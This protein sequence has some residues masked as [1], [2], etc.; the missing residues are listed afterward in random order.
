M[1]LTPEEIKQLTD[2]VVAHETGATPA[3]LAPTDTASSTSASDAST[4]GDEEN[5]TD[6]AVR[7]M[8]TERRNA[9]LQEQQR[10]ESLSPIRRKYEDTIN[11]LPEPVRAPVGYGLEGAAGYLGG[12]AIGSAT[13]ALFPEYV[14]GTTKEPNPEYDAAQA[15][16]KQPQINLNDFNS[17][18]QN[19]Q[20]NYEKSQAQLQAHEPVVQNHLQALQEHTNKMDELRNKLDDAHFNNQLL[21]DELHKAKFEHGAQLL[22]SPDLELH[23]LLGPPQTPP[24]APKDKNYYGQND[25]RFTN[26][27]ELSAANAARN[28]E[29]V[30]GLSSL[31][32]NPDEAIAKAPGMTATKSGVLGPSEVVGPF[33]EE[34]NAAHQNNI[35]EREQQK[36]IITKQIASDQL[37][38]ENKLN[39]ISAQQQA[40]ADAVKEHKKAVAEHAKAVPTLP[41]DVEKARQNAL[42][43]EAEYRRL[44]AKTP[45]KVPAENQMLRGLSAFGR[46]GRRFVPG[47]GAAVAPEEAMQAKQDYEAGNYGRMATHGAGALGAV[48]QATDIP[49]LVGVGNTMQI[50]SAVLAGY[51]YLNPGNL[52]GPK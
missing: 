51:D 22:R 25:R 14:P 13:K 9:Q 35:S 8:E 37:A 23:D 24:A 20:E 39:R 27:N 32:L 6:A 15:R 4:P 5:A 34:Q 47:L 44:L 50:P 31:G 38:A 45:P 17:N 21:Q 40:A 36:R 52:P 28:R 26:S 42:V 29:I 33:I 2:A 30:S 12:R 10:R 46:I 43:N 11:M 19:A 1:A 41:S 18:L 3:A 7:K 48:L 16:K 49:P